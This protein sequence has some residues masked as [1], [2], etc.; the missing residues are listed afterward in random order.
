MPDWKLH[1]KFD[2]D[3]EQSAKLKKMGGKR[4]VVDIMSRVN[5]FA[6]DKDLE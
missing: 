3:Q 1:G 4:S 6:N 5:L 2:F